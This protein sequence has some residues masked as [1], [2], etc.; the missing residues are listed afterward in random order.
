[1][2]IKFPIKSHISHMLIPYVLVAISLPI[3]TCVLIELRTN[4]QR[5]DRFL[6]FTDFD[7]TDNSNFKNKIIKQLKNYNNVTTS[8]TCFS[9]DSSSFDTLYATQA[10]QC[11][12][13]ILSNTTLSRVSYVDFI[14]LESTNDYYSEDNFINTDNEHVGIKLND[15]MKETLKEDTILDD[16]DYYFVLLDTSKHLKGFIDSYKDDQC[17]YII[18]YINNRYEND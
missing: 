5:K 1:M 9:K 12:M 14:K 7:L 10:F 18:D 2:K 3:I 8:I 6:M 17:A 13:L 11:D 4:P 15:D 16:E